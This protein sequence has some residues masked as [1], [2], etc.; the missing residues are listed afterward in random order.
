M[1]F[2]DENC[3]SV[4]ELNQAVQEYVEDSCGGVWPED[5]WLDIGE[6][7]RLNIWDELGKKQV[8]I[9]R[10]YIDAHG[11]RNTDVESCIHIE[12]IPPRPSIG[13]CRM[14]RRRSNVRD[15]WDFRR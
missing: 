11:F 12:W 14:R 6:H 15:G 5:D 8:A 3:P 7:W 10:D 9:Y 13:H 4:A 1:K 2:K